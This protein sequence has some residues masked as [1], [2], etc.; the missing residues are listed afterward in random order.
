MTKDEVKII[1]PDDEVSEMYKEFREYIEMEKQY[2][3]ESVLWIILAILLV[4]FSMIM[5][6][7]GGV[8]R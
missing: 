5:I 4:V 8:F 2:R 6:I 1:L 7:A 3:R